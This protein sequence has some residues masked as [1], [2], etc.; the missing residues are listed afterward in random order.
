MKKLL[1]LNTLFILLSGIF[2]SCKKNELPVTAILPATDEMSA[3]VE[4]N[5]MLKSACIESEYEPICDPKPIPLLNK[6]G[7]MLGTLLVSNSESE[8]QVEFFPEESYSISEVQL[9]AGSNPLDVPMN[10]NMIP[11][12]G[13]FSY[14]A[15]SMEDYSFLIDLNDIYSIPEML[16]EGKPIY[17]FAHAVMVNE[18]GAIESSWSEG[19]TFGT[20]RWGTY[21]EFQCCHPNPPTSGC[22]QH[23]ANCGTSIEGVFYYDN[24][25]HG[26]QKIIADVGEVVG[27]V[28]YDDGKIYFRLNG[29]WS[30]SDW[31][32]TPLKYQRFN[33]PGS[34]ESS[35]IDVEDL[36]SGGS[37][38]YYVSVEEANYYLLLLNIQ[39]CTTR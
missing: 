7:D 35:L 30:I 3:T 34:S 1:L 21:S 27:T 18:S 37:K 17:L 4:E 39:Y 29:D 9:W 19:K 38:G 20:S 16:L 25:I 24:T 31:Y 11:V 28:E 14:K 10:K 22:F 13:K 36:L 26:E 6:Q 32:S 5:F 2:G 8:L 15:S 23:T 33:A 12:P